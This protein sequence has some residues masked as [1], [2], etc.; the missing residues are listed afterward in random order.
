VADEP[1]YFGAVDWVWL[2]RRRN[3]SFSEASN[4]NT[5][6]IVVANDEGRLN[7]IGGVGAIERGWVGPRSGGLVER[8]AHRVLLLT[9]FL[10]TRNRRLRSGRRSAKLGG[11]VSSFK[12]LASHK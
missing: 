10:A 2:A 11:T 3:R 6:D 9:L 8:Y 12:G 5:R 4:G 1:G 7:E